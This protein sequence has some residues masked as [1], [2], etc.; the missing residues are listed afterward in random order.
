MNTISA[1]EARKITQAHLRGPAI[2][3]FVSALTNKIRSVA[4]K[5]E[6]GFD[7]W[8][9]LSSLRSMQPGHEQKAGIKQH[10]IEAG[11]KWQDH[12]DPD[13]G[14]PASRPYTTLSW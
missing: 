6:S 11:F 7:P 1:E 4:E 13:P 2:E 3:P 8:M 12:P 5:G 14:H 10:F 9:Y